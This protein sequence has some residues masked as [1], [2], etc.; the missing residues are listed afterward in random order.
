MTA[1][2]ERIYNKD[3]IGLSETGRACEACGGDIR[4]HDWADLDEWGFC[5]S[6]S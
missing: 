3:L 5:C 2:I 6:L 4:A 1:D